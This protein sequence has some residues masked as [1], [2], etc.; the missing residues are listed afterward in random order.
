MASV[1][2]DEIRDVILRAMKENPAL[3]Q[4][5]TQAIEA[6]NDSLIQSLIRAA[7]GA[8]VQVGRAAI[9]VLVTWL[10]G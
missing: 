4:Q 9:S 7:V 2:E 8:L 10:F 5:F 1:S 3:C 6:K